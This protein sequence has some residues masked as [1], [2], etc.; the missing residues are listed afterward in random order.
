MVPDECTPDAGASP[1]DRRAWF[2]SLVPDKLRASQARAKMRSSDSL[3]DYR[4]HR[5]VAALPQSINLARPQS[6]RYLQ[7]LRS[8][9]KKWFTAAEEERVPCFRLL[10][11]SM[12]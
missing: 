3:V 11:V 10:G 2:K 7:S 6:A 8:E 1:R 12:F 5:P 4:Q 9:P